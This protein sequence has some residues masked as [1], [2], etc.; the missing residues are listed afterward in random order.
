MSDPLVSV[1]M[2]VHNEQP[3]V[4]KAIASIL[5]QTYENFELII[6][7][8][9][10]TDCSLEI[11][12]SFTDCRIRVYSKKSEPPHLSASR[13]LGIAMANGRYIMLQDA[14]DT[15]E[16][17]RM[18]KQLTRAMEWPFRLVVGSSVRRI[19]G[20]EETVMPLS[21]NHDDIVKG[22]HRIRNRTTIIPG[23]ILAPTAAMRAVR[24]RLRFRYMQ[25]W[26][27]ILRLYESSL[28]RFTNCTEPLYTYY[29][30]DKGVIHKPKWLDYNIFVRNCQHRR[31][32]G[33]P[34]HASLKDFLAHLD[35]HPLEKYRW[36]SLRALIALNKRRKIRSPAASPEPPYAGAPVR[37]TA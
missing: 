10:S 11:C 24:Y 26:D 20:P 17:Q 9:Y 29:I 25:D 1:I 35:R 12:H 18:H 5:G 37:K 32:R 2:S 3:Y 13:N 34:E 4:A 16:P 36:L 15:A 28:V 23:T 27:H 21:E 30:R 6:I 8:D 33:L 31:R 22:F 14:D 7:D 19:E